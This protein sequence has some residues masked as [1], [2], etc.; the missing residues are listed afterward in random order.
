MLETLGRENRGNVTVRLRKQ[1]RRQ[2]IMKRRKASETKSVFDE[3]NEGIESES[4]TP[5]TLNMLFQQMQLPDVA[6]QVSAV[7]ML[8]RY[9]AGNESSPPVQILLDHGLIVPHLMKLLS[10]ENV[11]MKVEATWIL[12]NI[13]AGTHEQT[14]YLIN[15]GVIPPLVSMLSSVSTHLRIQAVW[16]LAN[17][18][19]DCVKYRDLVL[20]HPDCVRFL[21]ASLFDRD[22]VRLFLYNRFVPMRFDILVPFCRLIYSHRQAGYC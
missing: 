22:D 9:T 16:A 13:A 14:E 17:V 5:S 7:R 20:Q 2:E 11:E 12:A 3:S 18:A 6:K 1:Q 10:G 21:L 8:R 19:G 4:F 15:L